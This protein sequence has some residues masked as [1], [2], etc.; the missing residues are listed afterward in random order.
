[1]RDPT[2][3]PSNKHLY[4]YL[5]ANITNLLYPYIGHNLEAHLETP[6][7]LITPDL[8]PD[9]RLMDDSVV[10][11]WSHSKLLCQR[12]VMLFAAVYVLSFSFDNHLK[13][14]INYSNWI[15]GS[16]T[17]VCTWSVD[18]GIF[19]V[20]EIERQACVCINNYDHTYPTYSTCIHCVLACTS[21][22]G[23]YF[24]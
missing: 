14:L 6:S 2:L 15:L 8:D 19:F 13:F 21:L 7:T 11:R 5:L 10:S 3:E 12:F 18:S 23:I 16:N 22:E 17:L 4:L 24:F 20:Q 1:M 9:L